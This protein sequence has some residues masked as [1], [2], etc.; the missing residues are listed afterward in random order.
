MY[1]R[2]LVLL[3]LCVSVFFSSCSSKK[4][5]TSYNSGDYIILPDTE[6]TYSEKISY[7]KYLKKN[8]EM[9]PESAKK[10][11]KDNKKRSKKDTPLRPRKKSLFNIFRKD[12]SCSNT[13]EA[14]INDGVRDIK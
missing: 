6:K 11:I 2:I 4:R 7:E 1:K 10:L 12:K 3:L 8:Y 5:S 13:S 9:Q 14:V